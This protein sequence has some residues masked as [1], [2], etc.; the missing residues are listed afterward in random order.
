MSEGLFWKSVRVNKY[1]SLKKTKQTVVISTSNYTHLTKKKNH[2]PKGLSSVVSPPFLCTLNIRAG[3]MLPKVRMRSL[4]VL[5]G[6]VVLSWQVILWPAGVFTDSHHQFLVIPNC[7][8]RALFSTCLLHTL[9]A[10]TMPPPLAASFPSPSLLPDPPPSDHL[11]FSSSLCCSPL[12]RLPSHMWQIPI[13]YLERG[14]NCL[15]S[16]WW[17]DFQLCYTE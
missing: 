4:N 3:V 11:L 14:K 16:M 1:F 6:S 5:T 2:P 17:R 12:F 15:W 7:T 10:L 8:A 13:K 9:W